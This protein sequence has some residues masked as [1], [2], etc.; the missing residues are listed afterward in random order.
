MTKD[1]Q[2]RLT[3]NIIRIMLFTAIVNMAIALGNSFN[4]NINE[5]LAYMCLAHLLNIT[6]Q[7]MRG[8]LLCDWFH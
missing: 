4:G 5:T 8:E 2:S 3:N 6:V 1:Q 7:I